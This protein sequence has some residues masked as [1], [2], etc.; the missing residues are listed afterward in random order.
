MT[1]TSASAGRFHEWRV[2]QV[3]RPA[4]LVQLTVPQWPPLPCHRLLQIRR[5]FPALA[6]YPL[7]LTQSQVSLHCSQFKPLL[8]IQR[9]T[10]KKKKKNSNKQANKH[11]DIEEGR[12]EQQAF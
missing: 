3:R 12:Q 7:W 2:K 4:G 8:T 11:C 10:G 5:D 9:E 1:T 6:Q